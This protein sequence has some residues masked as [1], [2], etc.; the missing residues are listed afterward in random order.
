MTKKLIVE[1]DDRPREARKRQPRPLPKRKYA[2]KGASASRSRSASASQ[3]SHPLQQ[4][5]VDSTWDLTC[6]FKGLL[7]D[8]KKVQYEEIYLPHREETYGNGRY[9]LFS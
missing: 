4:R 8:Q 6:K 3:E 5:V 9:A 7:I 1:H 2:S